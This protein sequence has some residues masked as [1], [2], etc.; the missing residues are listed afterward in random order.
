MIC[1]LAAVELLNITRTYAYIWQLKSISPS[2]Q[3]LLVF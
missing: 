2:R 3:V 1:D